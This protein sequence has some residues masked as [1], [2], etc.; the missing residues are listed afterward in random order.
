[1]RESELRGT[2]NLRQYAEGEEAPQQR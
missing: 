1:M 2:E